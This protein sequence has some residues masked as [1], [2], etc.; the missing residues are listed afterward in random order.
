MSKRFIYYGSNLSTWTP[1]TKAGLKR[2]GIY[3]SGVFQDAGTT[4]SGNGDPVQQWNDLSG[5]SNHFIQLTGTKQPLKQAGSVDFDGSNDSIGSN[6]ADF[7]LDRTSWAVAIRFRL[8]NISGEKAI[9]SKWRSSDNNRALLIYKANSDNKIKVG[10]SFA[11]TAQNLTFDTGVVPVLGQYYNLIVWRDGDN[12]RYKYD[13]DNGTAFDNVGQIN[14]T[15]NSAEDTM[16]MNS[17]NNRPA[18]GGVVADLFYHASIDGTDIAD[19]NTYF[20]SL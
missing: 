10:I 11:G 8:D 4:P 2:W 5:N 14:S 7:N 12:K 9:Y 18:D 3:S 1:A 20:N 15:F 6:N 13:L 19:I 17:G 16:L